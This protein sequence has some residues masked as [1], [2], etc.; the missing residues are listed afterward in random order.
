MVTEFGAFYKNDFHLIDGQILL[1]ATTEEEAREEIRELPSP[2]ELEAG[3]IASDSPNGAWV[4][5]DLEWKL[6]VFVDDERYI[7]G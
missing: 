2:A 1:E 7:K 4:L 5:Q 6:C 3:N